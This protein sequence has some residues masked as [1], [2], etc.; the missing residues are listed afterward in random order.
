MFECDG[1]LLLV[2]LLAFQPLQYI[3]EMVRV[4]SMRVADAERGLVKVFVDVQERL[5]VPP[6]IVVAVHSMGTHV[7]LS[8]PT[9]FPTSSDFRLHW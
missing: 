9:A 4:L 1:G 2:P 8:F 5:T 3:F 7:I 6:A